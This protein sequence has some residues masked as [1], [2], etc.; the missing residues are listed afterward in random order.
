MI[1]SDPSNPK[2][3]LN[4]NFAYSLIAIVLWQTMIVNSV[5]EN[6]D[7]LLMVLQALMTYAHLFQVKLKLDKV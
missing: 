5:V 6:Q 7:D 2:N 4:Y 3:N 1:G